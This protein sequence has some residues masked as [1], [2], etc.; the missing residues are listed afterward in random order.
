MD[1]KMTKPTGLIVDFELAPKTN[2][3]H[4]SVKNLDL[5]LDLVAKASEKEDEFLVK[6][7]LWGVARNSSDDYRKYWAVRIY[8]NHLGYCAFHYSGNF[9]M[10]FA[11]REEDVSEVPDDMIALE[12]PNWGLIYFL[13][14][15]IFY[16]FEEIAKHCKTVFES[17]S[18]SSFIEVDQKFTID[19]LQSMERK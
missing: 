3:G 9:K 1:A 2:M 16:S 6:L 15:T 8:H 7:E 19:S 13:P 14:K 11:G 4:S 17:H 18:V 5:A 10:F 12:E